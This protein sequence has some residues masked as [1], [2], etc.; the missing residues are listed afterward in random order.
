MKIKLGKI[1]VLGATSMLTLVSVNALSADYD[2]RESMSDGYSNSD[3]SGIAM[4]DFDGGDNVSEINRT[5]RFYVGGGAGVS[6]LDIDNSEDTSVKVTDDSDTAYEVFAG[7]SFNDNFKLEGYY[8]DQGEA[9]LEDAN[10]NEGTLGYQSMGLSGI[11]ALPVL[12][13]LDVFLKAGYSKYESDN[14]STAV[15]QRVLQDKDSGAHVGV[16]V[17]YAVTDN[18]GLRLGY[19]LI[20]ED[21][22]EYAAANVVYYFGGTPAPQVIEP[23]A[24]PIP[25]PAPPPPP[26]AQQLADLAK[27]VYFITN[28]ATLT[29][30]AKRALDDAARVL[31]EHPSLNISVSAHTDSRA[32]NSYNQSLSERRARSV[33]SYLSSVGI[34]SSRMSSRGYGES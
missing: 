9:L 8:S 13:Q 19:N 1:V 28:K 34:S 23:I 22:S 31:K 12:D 21:S 14:E 11:L 15:S 16:G 25:A 5:N 24:A 3:N 6:K 33:V 32:S 26:P 4:I 27:N 2:V 10:G 29:T 20:N 17:E 7:Y 18:L 30:S